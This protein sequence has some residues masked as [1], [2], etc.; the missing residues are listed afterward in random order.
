[1]HTPLKHSHIH[2]GVRTKHETLFN[3]YKTVLKHTWCPESSDRGPTLG[4]QSKGKN[5]FVNLLCSF[6]N[7]ID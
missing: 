1:M 2:N 5:Y 7:I 4:I 3:N 6:R